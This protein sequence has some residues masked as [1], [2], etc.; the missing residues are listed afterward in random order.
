M[1]HIQM[2]INRMLLAESTLAVPVQRQVYLLLR[3]AML[4][5]RLLPGTRLPA[6]R[7]LAGELGISRNTVIHAYEQLLG[8]GWVHADRRG[9][10]VAALAGAAGAGGSPVPALDAPVPALLPT[11]SRRALERGGIGLAENLLRPFMPGVPAAD[12][13]PLVTWRRLLA[14]ALRQMAPH[15]L[16]RLDPAG[17]TELRQAIA[18]YLRP[19]RAVRCHA[20]QVII[21][22]GTQCG[23]RRCCELLTDPGDIAWIEE[24]GYNGARSALQAAGLTLVP[25][26]VDEHGIN[27]SAQDWAERTPKL[28]YLSPSHQYPLGAVLSMERRRALIHQAQVHGSWLLEDDYDSEFYHEAPP[29]PA[30]QSLVDTAPVLYLG[31][32][33]KS[34]FPGL[35]LGYIVMPSKVASRAVGAMEEWERTG[36]VPQQRALAA[37]IHE[38]GYSSHISR[39]RQLY[40][41]RQQLLRQA[42]DAHWPLPYRLLGGAGGIHVVLTLPA[43]VCDRALVARAKAAGLGPG[44]LSVCYAS[45]AQR[46]NG[47]LL[48]YAMLKEDDVVRYV[49][50]LAL[51][52]TAAPGG[53][54]ACDCPDQACRRCGQSQAQA[55][56]TLPACSAVPGTAARAAPRAP[57]PG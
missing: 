18:D 22:S 6:S 57:W 31:T 51:C 56:A 34:M 35:Q 44:A 24:P 38:G 19:A 16:G 23:L 30:L 52:V 1:S 26:P 15:E 4:S 50:A 20:D 29:P 7:K 40:R 12:A 32:F 41:E 43:H 42:L 54:G 46:V 5:G 47:L 48:G 25:I 17:E 37:F 36:H 28:I 55:G 11:L 27:P 39:M 14:A 45:A 21:T 8:D 53:A 3:Q 9:T 13:F 33:S 49:Q 2:I 10:V